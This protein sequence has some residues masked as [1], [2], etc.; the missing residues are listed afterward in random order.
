MAGNT[1][2]FSASKDSHW[3]LSLKNT[4]SHDLSVSKNRRWEKGE[5]YNPAEWTEHNDCSFV[6]RSWLHKY[7]FSF[8]FFTGIEDLSAVNQTICEMNKI[9]QA[10]IL[11]KIVHQKWKKAQRHKTECIYICWVHEALQKKRKETQIKP[12]VC[13]AN[14]PKCNLN[15]IQFHILYCIIIFKGVNMN[16]CLL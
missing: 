6:Q 5:K 3:A 14:L 12:F 7:F 10:L 2:F 16:T 11:S 8:I 1:W 9:L 15:L 4:H 13:L